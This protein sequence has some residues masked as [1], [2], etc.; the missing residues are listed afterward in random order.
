MKEFY[1]KERIYYKINDF[2]ADRPIL[3]FIHGVSGS[4]SAWLTYEEA[5]KDKYNILT[6]D[7]RG[8][9]KSKKFSKYIDY[10][11]KNFVRDLEELISFLDID[12]FILISHSY[13][14]LI[15]SEYINLHGDKVMANVFLSPIIGVEERIISKFLN[16]ILSIS[17]LLEFLPFKERHGRHVDY[18]KHLN[19]SDWNIKRSY[20]D[21]TNTDLRIYLYCLKHSLASKNNHSFD[22]INM[23]TLIVHGEKD[24]VI[25][26]RNAINLSRKIKNYQLSII[27]KADHIIVL[28][29]S[30]EILE[31]LEQFIEKNKN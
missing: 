14:T 25:P 12:R 4:S 19:T 27:S 7:I 17:K 23:P 11:I 24:T 9:G 29:N 8:H 1:F 30:K 28:N 21:V 20:A 13:A 5:L 22:K 3:V 10:E 18:L 6:F 15:A 2:K 31:I 16:F 26:V